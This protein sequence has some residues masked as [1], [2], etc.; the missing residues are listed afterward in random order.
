MLKYLIFT[1]SSITSFIVQAQTFTV[2][3]NPINIEVDLNTAPN[4]N[5]II[6]ES[7]ITNNTGDT[8]NLKWERITNDKPDCWE[9]SVFGV[10]IQSLPHIDSLTF[11]LNPNMEGLM[12]IS[13]FTDLMGGVPNAGEAEV[14]LKIT[15][16]NNPTDTLLVEFNFTVTGDNNCSTRIS[17]IED[18]LL[19][20]YPNP[21]TDFFNL[22]GAEE[23]EYL[24]VYNI[25]GDQM[26]KYNVTPGQR[27]YTGELPN[28]VFIIKLFDGNHDAIKTI[29]LV[30][31]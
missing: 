30:K 10:W 27:Y 2:T 11:D 1:L 15:N 13:V 22:R 8:L 26:Y 16:L 24:M 25:I 31:N 6:A 28:G 18:K 20:V 7:I 17:E 19:Q 9:T 29:K 4:P 12:N 21:M 23:I 3:P 14:V 5:E